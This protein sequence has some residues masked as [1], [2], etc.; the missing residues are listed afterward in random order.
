MIAYVPPP[1]PALFEARPPDPNADGLAWPV[2]AF[3]FTAAEARHVASSGTAFLG[4]SEWP[5]GPDREGMVETLLDN[6]DDSSR[7]VGAAAAR[8]IDAVSRE[9]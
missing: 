9:D 7:K 2:W 4:V 6:S 1:Y 5:N 3:G 8:K